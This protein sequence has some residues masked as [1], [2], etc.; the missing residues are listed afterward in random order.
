MKRL[1]VILAAALI[2]MSVSTTAF[3]VPD[4]QSDDE[5]TTSAVSEQNSDGNE[6]Q[7]SA[8]DE[9]T[10][11][12]NEDSEE[13]SNSEPSENTEST[14][15]NSKAEQE[16]SSASKI[17]INNMKFNTYNIK[18]VDMYI[19]IPQDM[20]VLTPNI[21]EDDPVL[22]AVKLTKKEVD[23]SFADTDTC[24]KAFAKD[25]SY[26]I[27]ITMTRNSQTKS[28]GNLTYLDEKKVQQVIDKLLKSNYTKGCA[29]NTYNNTLF[30]T[31]DLEYDSN[32]TH[33]YGIQ[34]YT[35]IKNRNITITLQSYNKEISKDQKALLS[36]IMQSV[37]FENVESQESLVSDVGNA[38]LGELDR[39]YLYIMAASLIAAAALAGMI[40]AGIKRRE[41]VTKKRNNTDPDEPES[42][43][44]NT[45]KKSSLS[46][47][48][49]KDDT[50]TDI[51]ED[52]KN[53]LLPLADENVLF[54][55]TEPEDKNKAS[56]GE[57]KV[58]PKIDLGAKLSIPKNPYTPVGKAE[59]VT[60]T[61]M[62]VTSE[63]A[64]LS[65]INEEAKRQAELNK[66]NNEDDD[67]V[68]FAESSPKPKTDIIQI[69]E[70]VLNQKPQKT[71]PQAINRAMAVKTP[72]DNQSQ[73]PLSNFER[74]FGNTA[75]SADAKANAKANINNYPAKKALA[76]EPIR[77]END[78]AA[79]NSPEFKK[80]EPQL[81]SFEKRFGKI[82]PAANDKVESEV[83]KETPVVEEAV[84]EVAEKTT[85]V[86]EE[87]IPEVTEETTVA[88]VTVP[89]ITEET[90][91]D[92]VTVPE[93][94]K[95]T[96]VAEVTVSEV[97]KETPV[98]EEEIVPEATEEA[99]VVV[100]E[101]V[102]EVT[103]ETPVVEVTVPEVKEETPVDEEEIVPE[104]TEEAT[105]VV[106]E[107]VSEVT[108]ETPVVEE[109]SKMKHKSDINNDI[110]DYFSSEDE[111]DIENNEFDKQT[112]D[113]L[114][115]P[116]KLSFL[117]KFKN[118]LFDADEDGL[119]ETELQEPEKNK[120]STNKFLNTL[121]DKF[122]YCPPVPEE[123][124][125][126]KS[127]TTKPESIKSESQIT[128]TKTNETEKTK[129][130]AE[131][132]NAAK[133]AK[134]TK[135][136]KD[137]PIELAIQKGENGNIVINDRNGNPLGIE[138]K[139]GNA[140]LKAKA[141]EAAE[142]AKIE[143]AKA[144][145]AS[146]EKAKK[147]AAKAEA[148]KAEA[149]RK[150][151]EGTEIY[152]APEQT[153]KNSKGKKGRKKKKKEKAINA[154]NAANL[155]KDG[156]I[157]TTEAATAGTILTAAEV[158]AK[159]VEAP[160]KEA[161][162]VTENS[163]QSEKKSKNQKTNPGKA[164]Q[165][166][167]EEIK[168]VEAKAETKVEDK[169]PVEAKTE[170]KVEDK[171]PVEAKTETK[172]EDKK[173][174]EAKAETKAEDKKQ[175]E[176]KTETKLEEVKEPEPPK[177]IFKRDSGIIFEQADDFF[178]EPI[179]P[180]TTIFTHI[181]RLES[182]NA[183]DYN[184]R[185]DDLLNGNP[186]PVSSKMEDDI[187]EENEEPF[188]LPQPVE[189]IPK[190]KTIKY[191]TAPVSAKPKQNRKPEL[192]P[193]TTHTPDPFAADS[194]EIPLKDLEQ[195]DSA[196]LS[197]MLKKSIGKIFTDADGED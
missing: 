104:A 184:K 151:R 47:D 55:N 96:P 74:R 88:E 137:S 29:K 193:E 82:Q 105:V 67:G 140:E 30:L 152:R 170:T 52:Y 77:S 38:T 163:V 59:P 132:Y 76:T 39:R 53:S 34:Q 125:S 162:P 13:S 66:A 192:K 20:Y 85:V 10:E 165:D 64:K 63:I 69:G 114:E 73:K 41:T 161:V 3:A 48:S 87:N 141:E 154:A 181:P 191:E 62:S 1:A 4:E 19:D 17:D 150:A 136:Q 16:S 127:E 83:I 149:A 134:A 99:T 56:D 168:P 80:P 119:Y 49:Q 2:V 108:E 54:K 8:A 100:E 183:D 40:I 75:L 101:T 89:E 58:F 176:T 188:I 139:D 155:V 95:E 60:K 25:F 18:N 72:D 169:K 42:K 128:E 46:V 113:I 106:E 142:K 115:Q 160:I 90:P 24:I 68:V 103:E 9:N 22:D 196:N 71:P 143:A 122:K 195:K 26:D 180:K 112:D 164:Q 109:A 35:V 156:I 5:Q 36:Y 129:E 158:L 124:L 138:V 102:S 190:P 31:L 50:D 148:A 166:D 94:T 15:E 197:D 28:I 78:D 110:D 79:K 98:D 14:D 146:A 173:P 97:T 23:E 167:K 117:E 27:T 37:F 61:D 120:E 70:S 7:D 145:K 178:S 81:S 84:P 153:P 175:S 172:A 107:T 194:E 171:K 189:P 65:I 116:Q 43:N 131:I 57:T 51:D 44:K 186:Y 111:T 135:P 12:N 21:A 187:E 118:K 133:V 179:V 147:E 185:M 11:N 32:D 45:E 123:E 92:E 6:E 174:V 86:E 182:V 93:V 144:E 91:V 177:F 157:A 126:K 121:R 33:I 130:S 159:A